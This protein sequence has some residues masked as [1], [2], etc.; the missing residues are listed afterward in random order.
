[1]QNQPVSSALP[2]GFG[3]L[4]DIVPSIQQDVRYA[5]HHNFI[6]NP[7]PGY[8]KPIIVLTN[9]AALGLKAVQSELQAFGLGL[10]VYD[11]YRPQKTVD[12]FVRWSND[13]DDQRMKAEFYPDLEKELI[14]GE[15]YIL[16]KSA[17]TRGSTV[18]LTI[19]PLETPIQLQWQ[20]RDK[21]IS[22]ALAEGE[23]WPDNS[24]D[25]GTG[26]DCFD[27]LSHTFNPKIAPHVRANRILLR[28]LMEK[29][30]FRGIKCE[31]WHFTLK[32]EPYP[33]TY[34]DFD[35]A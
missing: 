13:H 15:G 18:D 5:C 17:H 22:G 7:L 27:E 34:F 16:P 9:A 31:W 35:V 11:A 30:G 28:S 32:D 21:L 6:G 1:V 19:V 3:Y 12:E 25:M 2:Q 23:R 14:L 8:S 29:H 24:I 20:P 26:F 4:S 33:D 10:K